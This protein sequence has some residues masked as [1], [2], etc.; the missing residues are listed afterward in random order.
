MARRVCI[1]KI[2]AAHGVRGEVRLHAFTRDPLA[3]GSYGLLEDEKG[4]R[5]FRILSLRPANDHLVARF[6]GISDRDA[7]RALA[8]IS[9]YVPR[10]RLPEPEADN[11]YHTD[12]VGLGVKTREGRA[13][14]TV[15]AVQD[16]GAGAILEIAPEAGGE[17]VMLPFSEAFVPE[18]DIAAGF[19][20]A[21]PPA[22]LF[23]SEAQEAP[24]K[25]RGR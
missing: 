9:L 16:F 22:G 14:G 7:A 4:E 2:G 15:M 20:V 13:L 12:L 5:S 1:A 3:V 18:I 6:D 11:F 10:E 21:D 25:R 19:L 23:E 8:N 24:S 17:S